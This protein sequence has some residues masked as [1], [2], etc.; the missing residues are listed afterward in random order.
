MA[1]AAAAPIR[2]GRTLC[3]EDLRQIL[4]HRFPLLMLD[5]VLDFEPGKYIVGSKNVTANEIHFLGHFPT[6]AIMPGVLIVE[7]LAQTLHVLDALT[8]EGDASPDGPLLKFL[9]SVTMNFMR[10]A[11]PG[12]QLRLEVDIVKQMRRGVVGNAVARVDGAIIA[13]GELTLMLKEGPRNE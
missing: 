12:D 5:K 9:G 4:A 6:V 3:F 10:P 2:P 8:R 7:A 11:V 1:D 13:K